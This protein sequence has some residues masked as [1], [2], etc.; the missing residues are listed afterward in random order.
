MTGPGAGWVGVCVGIG[1]VLGQFLARDVIGCGE[2]L[3]FLL[4]VVF[5]LAGGAVGRYVFLPR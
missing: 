1:I 4:T 3:R 2:G 5:A